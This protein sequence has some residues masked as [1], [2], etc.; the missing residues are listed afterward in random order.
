MWAKRPTAVVMVALLLEVARG[1][2]CLNT[3]TYR[4]GPRTGYFASGYFASNG[5]CEDGGPGSEYSSCDLGIDCADCAC[6]RVDR[7]DSPRASCAA[8]TRALRSRTAR[9]WQAALA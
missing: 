4:G 6:P 9:A 8:L 1:E 3:C 2:T 5:Y 7:A